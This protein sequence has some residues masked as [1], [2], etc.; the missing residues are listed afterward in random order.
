MR[1]EQR[2]IWLNL[3]LALVYGAVNLTVTK[4]SGEPIYPPFITWDT[5]LHW[6]IGLMLIP[7]FALYFYI[8][9]FLTQAK[10]KVLPDFK[11]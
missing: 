5:P 7:W 10:L 4:V 11:N 3:I 9:F 6:F 2:F 8:E 1:F